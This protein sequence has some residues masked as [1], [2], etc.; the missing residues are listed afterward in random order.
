MLLFLSFN[1]NENPA[2]ALQYLE[3]SDVY[4]CIGIV[5]GNKPIASTLIS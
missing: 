2:V 1:D 3:E 5:L 4:K